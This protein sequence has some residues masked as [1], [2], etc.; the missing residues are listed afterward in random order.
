VGFS[1]GQGAIQQ[2]EQAA[3]TFQSQGS[4]M[5]EAFDISKTDR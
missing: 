2:N 5:A 4:Q 3:L 1:R